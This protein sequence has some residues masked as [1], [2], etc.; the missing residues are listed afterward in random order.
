MSQGPSKVIY[1]H[2][3][4]EINDIERYIMLNTRGI[5]PCWQIDRDDYKDLYICGWQNRDVYVC[6]LYPGWQKV[7][8]NTNLTFKTLCFKKMIKNNLKYR[9]RYNLVLLIS[10]WMIFL[11]NTRNWLTVIEDC[12]GLVC[13]CAT[14]GF[15]NIRT[16]WAF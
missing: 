6:R 2:K 7:F 13:N 10:R 9:Q 8:F 3:V 5:S 1:K 12:I 14:N 4:D 15:L 16:N 11:M